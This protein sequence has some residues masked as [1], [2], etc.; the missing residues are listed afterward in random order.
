MFQFVELLKC[1][2][3]FG[4]SEFYRIHFFEKVKNDEIILKLSKFSNILG[5][6]KTGG[7][8]AL[9]FPRAETELTV[10]R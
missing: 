9:R 5:K 10:Y 3:H 4:I 6:M 2:K 1:G 7:A 8:P